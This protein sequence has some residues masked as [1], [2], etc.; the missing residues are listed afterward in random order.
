MKK[1]LIGVLLLVSSA[2]F[3]QTLVSKE[4]VYKLQG[5][6]SDSWTVTEYDSNGV[7]V[8]KYMVYER[9][10][11]HADNIE[12]AIEIKS[13]QIDLKSDQITTLGFLFD[14]HRWPMT[15]S[16]REIWSNLKNIPDIMFPLPMLD[17]DLNEYS[18]TL[19]NR[20]LFYL[21]ALGCKYGNIQ[22]GNN[23]KLQIKAL[24]QQPGTTIQ[25]ILN[26][27]DPR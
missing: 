20:D 6:G 25:D 26:F 8:A 18:L 11:G 21:A 19:A 5:N 12:Q 1:I 24:A 27:Q 2:M 22:S 9:P 7:V 4:I 17:A 10:E 15:A 14:G 3:C 23:L 16:A 13:K